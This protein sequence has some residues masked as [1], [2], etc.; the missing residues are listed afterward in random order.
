MDYIAGPTLG[1]LITGRPPFVGEHHG[2][3]LDRVMHADPP[4]SIALSIFC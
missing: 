4:A 2:A 1:K 3:T